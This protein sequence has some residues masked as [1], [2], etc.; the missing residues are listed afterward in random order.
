MEE[1]EVNILKPIVLKTPGGFTYFN[2]DEIVMCCA[3]GNCSIVYTTQKESSLRVLHKIAFI[4]RNY[5]NNNFIR[6][7][8]SF[9]INLM[10]L[11]KLIIKK[12]Q[13]YLKGG[14]VV[15]LSSD[16]WKILKTRSLNRNEK[17]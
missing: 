17:I 8:K 6:C 2:Y 13:A 10:Y 14:L 12:H 16:Y 3:E 9:I 1:Q 15:S 5:C 11:E 4:E 7:H